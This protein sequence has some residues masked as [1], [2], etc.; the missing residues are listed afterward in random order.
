V[1]QSRDFPQFRAANL[2]KLTPADT[3]VRVDW[4]SNGQYSSA[5][6][7]PSRSAG[8]AMLTAYDPPAFMT[9]F[10]RIPGQL[11]SWSRAV[12]GWFEESIA[13]QHVVPRPAEFVVATGGGYF[14]APSMSALEMVL[15]A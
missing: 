13:A 5:V 1:A 14:F 6:P 10:N 9:D 2:A 8:W 3:A 12:S 15:A 11:A 7:E 4:E